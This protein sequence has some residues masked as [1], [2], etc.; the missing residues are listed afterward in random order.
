MNIPKFLA[1]HKMAEPISIDAATAM[2]RKVRD[3]TT[4]EVKWISTWVQLT[5]DGLIRRIY[6]C[7][8]SPDAESI[9]KILNEVRFPLEGVYPMA[10][11]DPSTL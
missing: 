6:C 11:V 2:G 7:W 5:E 10:V 4:R 9:R 8:E 3:L 1:V